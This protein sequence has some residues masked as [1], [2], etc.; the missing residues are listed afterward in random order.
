MLFTLAVD[1][2]GIKFF[3]KYH[4][5]HL[6]KALHTKYEISVDWTGSH[7]CGLAID[8]YY[9]KAYVDISIQE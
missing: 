6:Y 5:E 2:L 4:A 3:N 9:D 7:Y 1:D 8:W